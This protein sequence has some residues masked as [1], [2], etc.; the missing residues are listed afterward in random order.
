VPTGGVT[1]DNA[2]DYIRAGAAALGM[3]SALVS[4]S[5]VEKRDFR[6]IAQL[7]ADV[8]ARVQAARQ[9]R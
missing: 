6:A 4:P 5:L 1:P 2:A 3:G 7:A 9:G 8:L